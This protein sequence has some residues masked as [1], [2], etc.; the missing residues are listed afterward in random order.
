MYT[1]MANHETSTFPLSL[2]IVNSDA[3]APV[4][5]LHIS[6]DCHTKKVIGSCELVK[7]V[8]KSSYSIKTELTGD[9]KLL[10]MIHEG[11]QNMVNLLGYTVYDQICPSIKITLITDADWKKG[12]AFYEYMEDGEWLK[13]NDLNLKIK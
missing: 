11:E 1:L 8:T 5:F 2:A 7:P 3:H 12:K 9:Y 4:L 13:V 10:N 6:V